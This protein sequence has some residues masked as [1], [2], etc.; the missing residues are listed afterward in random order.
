[1]KNFAK[2]MDYHLSEKFA[3]KKSD[4]ELKAGVFVGPD[5]RN[6]LKD[7]KFDHYV[8]SLELRAWTSFKYNVHCT[9]LIHRSSK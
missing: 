7:E 9:M 3:I 5:I 8:N 4:A 2:A 1:M 6:L